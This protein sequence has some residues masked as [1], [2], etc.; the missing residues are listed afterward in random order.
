MKFPLPDAMLD[1][2]KTHTD[3]QKKVKTKVL[4]GILRRGICTSP[5]ILRVVEHR[6]GGNWPG[7]FMLV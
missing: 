6:L 4:L 3:K 7:H 1:I 5:I 2:R